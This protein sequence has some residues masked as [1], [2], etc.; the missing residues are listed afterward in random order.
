MKRVNPTYTNILFLCLPEL[1]EKIGVDDLVAM[2]EN[3]TNTF[4]YYVIIEFTYK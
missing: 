3:V 4:S 2:L 1:W